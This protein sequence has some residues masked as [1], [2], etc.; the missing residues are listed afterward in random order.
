MKIKT[1]LLATLVSMASISSNSHAASTAPKPP[2]RLKGFFVGAQVGYVVTD[3][4]VDSQ[5]TV[6]NPT[7]SG[8]N[9]VAGR[10]IIGGISIGYDHLFSN[11]MSLGASLSAN[12]AGTT[13]HTSSKGNFGT[14]FEQKTTVKLKQAYDL[15]AQ[16][17]GMIGIKTLLYVKAGPTWGQWQG[18]TKAG[19]GAVSTS[20]DF[21]STKIGFIGGVGVRA[22]IHDHVNLTLEC[23]YRHFGKIDYQC[24]S[25]GGTVINKMTIKP[26]ATS[27]EVGVVYTM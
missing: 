15:C 18:D 7:I 25:P 8:T 23:N 9:H 4:K 16:F 27:F 20:G 3:T 21:K 17:G 6:A 26:K 5:L 12:L 19:S 14:D 10:G 1:F 2:S 13:G 11:C 24:K 22:A